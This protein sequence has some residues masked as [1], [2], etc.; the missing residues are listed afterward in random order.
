MFLRCSDSTCNTVLDILDRALQC[1]RCGDL[2]EIGLDLKS[3]DAARLPRLWSERKLSPEPIDRS[4]IWRFREF[5]PSRWY[6]DKVV[7]L[8]E[9]NVPLLAAPHSAAYGGLHQLWFKHLGWN[10]TGS[11]KDAGMTAAVTHAAYLGVKQVACASTGNTAASVAA[12]AARAGIPARVYLPQGAISMAKL[13]QSLD[14]GA[15]I[16]QVQ[17]NFDDALEQLLQ[18]AGKEMYFLNSI[19]PF[20]I[21]GQKIIMMGLME[22][23]GWN[24]PDFIV[25]PGGNLGNASAFGKS[26]LEMQATGLIRTLPRVVVVQAEGANP[27]ART[28]R[29]GVDRLEPIANPQTAATAICIGAPRSWKKAL[30]VLRATNGLCLDVTED[31][32]AEAKAVIGQEGIGCEPASATTLAG[33]RKLIREGAMDPSARVVA[34]LTGHVLKDTEYVIRRNRQHLEHLE[35][36]REKVSGS[37]PA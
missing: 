3:I 2:L 10:P 20:R 30:R 33:I 13:A 17:G 28:W 6:G 35:T 16:V 9:G 36:S 34:I 5:L 11:F 27:L 29:S 15:E 22:Q 4:G 8:E 32:I 7:T 25:L 21:E 14:Y 31:A 18:S 1:P 26:L 24:P 19:N 37:A 12:Y 23:L